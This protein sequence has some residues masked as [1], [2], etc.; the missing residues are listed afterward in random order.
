MFVGRWTATR[1]FA[2]ELPR[3]SATVADSGCS[4]A[5]NRDC[6]RKGLVREVLQ[7]LAAMERCLG[8]GRR[9]A[10]RKLA[11][12]LATVAGGACS[13]ADNQDR[14]VQGLAWE[15]SQTF[16]MTE[17]CLYDCLEDYLKE[18]P[19]KLVRV[20]DGVCL[21]AHNQDRWLPRLV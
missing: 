7:S 19:R 4:E 12:K 3:K 6:S 9:R 18:E 14:S 13:Q 17:H 21:E 15:A 10:G 16:N 8:E 11:K 1:Q 20:A 2:K 5:D